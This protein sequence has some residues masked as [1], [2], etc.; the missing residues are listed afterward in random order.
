MWYIHIYLL[1]VMYT[2]CNT[3][4]WKCI[5]CVQYIYT[6]CSFVWFSCCMWCIHI[7]LFYIPTY[8]SAAQTH[9]NSTKLHVLHVTHIHI[10]VTQTQQENQTKLQNVY[11]HCTQ[12]MH[13]HITVLQC[14]YITCNKYMCIYHIQHMQ[15]KQSHW[16]DAHVY[17]LHTHIHCACTHIHADLLCAPAYKSTGMWRLLGCLN[18]QVIFRERA[19][20]YRALLRKITCKDT[21]SP[22][23]ITKHTLTCI[24]VSCVHL[25]AYR[26]V[27]CMCIT[28]IHTYTH[29]TVIPICV[30]A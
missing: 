15:L 27:A 18:L 23:C 2:H 28:R 30:C 29:N 4:I 19:I 22:P 25:F 13:F 17:T 20:N 14:V 21:A 7:D 12:Q 6:F 26:N 1:H 9:A 11:I 10:H 5:C 16:V 8:K 24:D 3:V